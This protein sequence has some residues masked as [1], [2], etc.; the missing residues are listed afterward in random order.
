VLAT[1]RWCRFPEPGLHQRLLELR[2][3]GGVKA[4]FFDRDRGD[5]M[6]W[7][8]GGGV[9]PSPIDETAR[10][11]VA[12]NFAR[13]GTFRR[14]SRPSL[15]RWA[16]AFAC[17]SG[18]GAGPGTAHAWRAGGAEM[19]AHGR[20]VLRCRDAGARLEQFE[21]TRCVLERV[22]IACVESQCEGSG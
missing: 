20:L 17:C 22:S 2:G 21:R 7:R 12:A 19:C 6:A 4:A 3:D 10:A 5:G 1:L 11:V 13:A 9:V 16:R 14:R 8:G 18:A 15:R